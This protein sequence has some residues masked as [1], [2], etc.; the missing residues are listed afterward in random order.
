MKFF[1]FLILL[2]IMAYGELQQNTMFSSLSSE[3]ANYEQRTL[4][5][6]RFEKRAVEATR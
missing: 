3:W 5:L 1:Y 4:E 6:K 2:P